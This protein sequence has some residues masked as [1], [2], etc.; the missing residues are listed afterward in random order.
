MTRTPADVAGITVTATIT[1]YQTAGGASSASV[2]VGH[3]PPT[4]ARQWTAEELASDPTREGAPWAGGGVAILQR[5]SSPELVAAL[6]RK[7][8]ELEAKIR[9]SAQEVIE[10]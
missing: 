10:P 2:N 5:D 9:G 7:V 4:L 8:R 3:L 6:K 1:L